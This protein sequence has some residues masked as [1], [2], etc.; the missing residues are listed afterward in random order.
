MVRYGEMFP[1]GLESLFRS[2]NQN[3]TVVSVFQGGIKVGIVSNIARQTHR[4]RAC[5]PIN[6]ELTSKGGL[7]RNRDVGCQVGGCHGG[8]EIDRRTLRKE[9]GK[10]SAER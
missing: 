7:R 4:C 1:V 3:T 2:A 6:E 8:R 5:K 9:G 10:L